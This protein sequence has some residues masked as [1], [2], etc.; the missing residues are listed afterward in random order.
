MAVSQRKFGWFIVNDRKEDGDI[1]S[2]VAASPQS[3]AIETLGRTAVFRCKH[4][5]MK[6]EVSKRSPVSR[7]SQVQCFSSSLIRRCNA[8]YRS[9]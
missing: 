9:G 8:A 5:A 1:K 2:L 6:S 3:V 7:C 4:T